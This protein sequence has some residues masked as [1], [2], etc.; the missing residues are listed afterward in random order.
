MTKSKF[1]YRQLTTKLGLPIYFMNLPHA[2]TVGVG[3]LVKAGTREETWP[4]EAGLEVVCLSR[5][6]PDASLL[7][8]YSATP[9]L[10][11]CKV[12]G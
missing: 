2:P 6:H 7:R 11:C 12:V 3:V 4:A 5:I 10:N 1:N 9:T 8:P